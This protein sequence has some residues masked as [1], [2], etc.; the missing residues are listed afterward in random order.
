MY[1]QRICSKTAVT[2]RESVVSDIVG[3][4]G[5]FHLN[6]SIYVSVMSFD[7]DPHQHM[8]GPLQLKNKL[9]LRVTSLC[10][11]IL[12]TNGKVSITT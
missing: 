2:W 5:D 6:G 4:G 9:D 3:G 11:K 1:K 12:P 8:L 7:G 10:M